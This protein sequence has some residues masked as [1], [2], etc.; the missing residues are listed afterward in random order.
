M[1]PIW[2]SCAATAMLFKRPP[3]TGFHF[4][5]CLGSTIPLALKSTSF[6]LMKRAAQK[7]SKFHCVEKLTI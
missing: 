5:A 6:N 3:R 4:L 7:Q 2:V 1:E